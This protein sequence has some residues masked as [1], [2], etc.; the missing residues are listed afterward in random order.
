MRI[1]LT[2]DSLPRT[3]LRHLH[4]LVLDHSFDGREFPSKRELP[5]DVARAAAAQLSAALLG[6]LTASAESRSAANLGVVLRLAGA[7]LLRVVADLLRSESLEF[8][9]DEGDASD[10][11]ENGGDAASAGACPSRQRLLLALI[12][13]VAASDA[14]AALNPLIHAIVAQ[15]CIAGTYVGAAH[16]EAAALGLM[17]AGAGDVPRGLGLRR[18]GDASAPLTTREQLVAALLACD[19]AD[20]PRG[21][22]PAWDAATLLPLAEESGFDEV[23]IHLQRK[24]GTLSEIIAAYLVADSF[25]LRLQALAFLQSESVRLGLT[26]GGGQGGGQAAGGEAGGEVIEL[27]RIVL[28]RLPQLLQLDKQLTSRIVRGI[29]PADDPALVSKLGRYPRLEFDYLKVSV[30]DR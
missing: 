17:A 25:P 1:L 18:A 8:A 26:L 7:T 20:A 5:A 24:D 23:V 13:T 14:C 29:F 27:R 30:S 11:S 19:C 10:A 16:A 9:P 21:A 6:M 22:L 28:E 4:C 12:R 15:Q 2:V 3:H